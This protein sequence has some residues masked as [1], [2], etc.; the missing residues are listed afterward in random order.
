MQYIHYF[1]RGT[2]H[3]IPPTFIVQKDLP[4]WV[5]PGGSL[6]VSEG[7]V[8]GVV[9]AS[10]NSTNSITVPLALVWASFYTLQGEGTGAIAIWG[11]S[12]KDEIDCYHL[13]YIK[14]T[15]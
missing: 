6:W 15:Q 14:N 8:G 13:S 1:L 9:C 5:A 12:N 7:G 2:K 4:K 10:R 3:L 11:I